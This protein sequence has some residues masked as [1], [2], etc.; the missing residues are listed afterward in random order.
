MATRRRGR[1]R[2]STSGHGVILVLPRTSVTENRKS[3]PTKSRSYLSKS[4]RNLF[5][6]RES[7][8]MLTNQV[9]DGG[10]SM[11]SVA[12]F[13]GKE[14]LEQIAAKLRPAFSPT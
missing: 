1:K 9:K 4:V 12:H 6:Q 3:S 5:P 2:S 14:T 8:A 11:K 10:G 13:T 7:L